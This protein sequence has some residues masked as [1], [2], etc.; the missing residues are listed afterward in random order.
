MYVYIYTYTHIHICGYTCIHV[1]D[2]C[3]CDRVFGY[4]GPRASQPELTRQ[5][6]ARIGGRLTWECKYMFTNYNFRKP[7]NVNNDTHE[8]QPSGKIL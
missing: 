6:L 3:S 5:G 7:L 2:A 4:C 8:F 1:Q